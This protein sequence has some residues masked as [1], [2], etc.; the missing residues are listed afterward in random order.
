MLRLKPVEAHATA[1]RFDG[2]AVKVELV[3]QPQDAV[4]L[5]DQLVNAILR[6]GR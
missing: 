2:G 6:N 4:R 1:K 3:F 5:S